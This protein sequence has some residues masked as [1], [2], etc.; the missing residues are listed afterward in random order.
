[1]NFP[2]KNDDSVLFYG[3]V[4]EF[5]DEDIKKSLE[6]YSD[7]KNVVYEINGFNFEESCTDYLEQYSDGPSYCENSEMTINGK[8]KINFSLYL[9]YS[10]RKFIM[11][12][13]ENV[14]VQ[15]GLGPITEGDIEIYDYEGNMIKKIETTTNYLVLRGNNCETLYD[16]NREY[17]IKLIDNKIHYIDA[18]ERAIYK[19]FD[20]KTFEENIIGTINAS[21]SQQC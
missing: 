9:P 5:I 17:N 19:T 11:I 20:L 13:P 7:Y 10:E 8:I 12:T 2:T 3:D 4:E 21:T 16:S 15:K 14:I 18:S 1:M 6:M